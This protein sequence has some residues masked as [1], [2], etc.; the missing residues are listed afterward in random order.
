[1]ARRYTTLRKKLRE[2]ET[3][4]VELFT[5]PPESPHRHRLSDGVEERLGALKALLSSEMSSVPDA[6]PDNLLQIAEILSE[7][8]MAF[9]CAAAV[10]SGGSDRGRSPSGD[11]D[12]GSVDMSDL[13][14][15]VY[16]VPE[17]LTEDREGEEEG[18]RRAWRT[19]DGVNE[20][21]SSAVRA[22][23]GSDYYR[24][25]GVG[26]VLGAF[27]MVVLMSRFSICSHDVNYLGPFTPT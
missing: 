11:G 23:V 14:F 16:D 2:L 10:G 15:K 17:E 13:G 1:M 19:D 25:W 21:P 20:E 8:D 3:A 18:D 22:N 7:L 24:A 4:V 9:R 26:A 27:S 12:A 5:L 6:N